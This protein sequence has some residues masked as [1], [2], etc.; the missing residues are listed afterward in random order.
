MA[1]TRREIERE[2]R[3]RLLLEA[4][5]R[6][7]GR[8]PFDEATMQEVAAEAQIGM[9]GLYEH[10]PSKQD[11]YEQVVLH[12]AAKLQRSA[13][14]V[15]KEGGDPRDLLRRLAL[16]YAT[17]F[18]QHPMFLPMF[19]MEK[20]RFE[21]NMETRFGPALWKVHQQETAR[22]KRILEA[23][24]RKKALRREPLEFLAQLCFDILHAS[25]WY[26]FHHR[27]TEEVQTCVDRALNVFFTAA[28]PQR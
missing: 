4:A 10:F 7:F 1:G 8:K 15:L 21:W 18:V 26:R 16:A 25:L 23:L 19:L 3:R 2:Q 11:L 9:Q 17:V 28:A 27:P 24:V 13:E 12:R 22:V 6:V 5:E 20:V 14:E